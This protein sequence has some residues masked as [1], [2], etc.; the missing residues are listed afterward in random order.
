[1]LTNTSYKQGLDEN[2]K[3]KNL[4]EALAE[5]CFELMHSERRDSYPYD[6]KGAYSEMEYKSRDGF[7]ANP[8]NKGGFELKVFENVNSIVGSGS[9]PSSKEANKRIERMDNYN[10]ELALEELGYTEKDLDK[11]DKK[12]EELYDKKDEIG[13]EDTIMFQV[14][15]MYTGYER[16]AHSAYVQVI[17]NW[18][19]PYHRTSAAV[20]RDIGQAFVSEDVFEK[21]IKWKTNRSFRTQVLKHV[22][23]GIKKLF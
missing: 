19:C 2:K 10:R 3:I 16:G 6:F 22:K 9:M 4:F 20:S 1:M 8:Y 13:S 18:E 11:D 15:V 7:M 12:Y 21:K 23:N 5:E 17:V 14:N